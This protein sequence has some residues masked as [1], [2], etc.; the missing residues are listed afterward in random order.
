[1]DRVCL[2][3]GI[4]V[5]ERGDSTLQVGLHPSSRVVLADTADVRALLGILA[6]GVEPD[7]VSRGQRD[8]L[9]RLQ[10]AGLIVGADAAL[11]R[12]RLRE[13]ASVE[14]CAD[15]VLTPHLV[16]LLGEA[17]LH[18]ARG[19]SAGVVLV[20]TTGAEPRRT[21]IDRLVQSDTP[22]LLVTAVAGRVRVGPYVV[23][24]LTACLR[25]LDAHQTDHDP[26]HP[27]VV[28]QH[29]EVDPDDRPSPGDLGLALAWAVRDL[30]AVV[31]GDRPTTWSATVDLEDGE[32]VVQGWRR[33]PR[34]GCAW[35]D[36]L[37]G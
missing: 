3:R 18:E 30:K 35:G 21:Q 15:P 20:A 27:L 34:C 32:P 4:R 29:V 22:H 37:T 31:E 6:Y 11:V 5:S 12:S 25:C 28:E 23:P 9:T 13:R 7:R 1:M 8:V 16:R 14:V 17:G 10:R 36:A 33:H 2:R 26:R 19:K 24:G